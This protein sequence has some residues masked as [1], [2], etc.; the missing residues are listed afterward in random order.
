MSFGNYQARD[1]KL[2]QAD[3]GIQLNFEK[4]KALYENTKPIQGKRECLNIRPVGERGR[5]HERIIKVT[6]REYYITCNSWARI[7][8]KTKE[9]FDFHCRA[10]TFGKNYWGGETITIHTPRTSSGQ[11]AVSNLNAPSVYWFYNYKLPKD[12]SL[13]NHKGKKYIAHQT[14]ENVTN[15]YTLDKGDIVFFKPEK[16]SYFKPLQVHREYTR[17]LNKQK[18][19]ELREKA[20]P[21]F[22]YISTM[23]DLVETDKWVR[24]NPLKQIPDEDLFKHDPDDKWLE[25]VEIYKNRIK[26]STGWYDYTKKQHFHTIEYHKHRLNAIFYKHLYQRMKPLDI[27]EVPL[28][29]I[30]YDKF[31]NWE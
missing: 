17:T 15:Y 3:N 4:A 14:Q 2:V 21:L 27:H 6:D 22:N 23:I 7:D 26:Q 9:V 12:F 28:G 29:K 11:F 30:C 1:S 13:V 19:K 16:D 10:I 20:K 25:L 18:T 24:D 8:T 5:S 31:K